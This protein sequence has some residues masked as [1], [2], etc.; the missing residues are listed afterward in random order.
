LINKIKFLGS[1]TD[2]L[3]EN[4]VDHTELLK[5]ISTMAQGLSFL[6]EDLS[7]KAGQKSFPPKPSVAHRDFK[8]KNVLLRSDLSAVISD[9]GLAVKFKLGDEPGD[10]HPS[11]K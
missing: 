6:H 8:S 7:P 2:F 1:L 3:R 11:G 9:F 4:T 10:S 5:I